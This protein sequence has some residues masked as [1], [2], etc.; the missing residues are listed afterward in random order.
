MRL[1]LL[2]LLLLATVAVVLADCNS[3]QTEACH[4]LPG[5]RS[6]RSGAFGVAAGPQLLAAD[7]LLVATLLLP[8]LLEG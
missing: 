1:L 4:A 8:R 3:P 6:A 7:L 5:C 2:L